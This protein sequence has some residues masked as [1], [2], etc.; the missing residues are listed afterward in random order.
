MPV[1]PCPPMGSS[2]VPQTKGM[3]QTMKKTRNGKPVRY[4][5]MVTVTTDH[6]VEV[7]ATDPEHAR[8]VAG[9][10]MGTEFG[11]HRSVRITEVEAI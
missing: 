5:W 8:A 7:T 3:G 6:Y 1:L 4:R 9:R 2:A 11:S 10:R